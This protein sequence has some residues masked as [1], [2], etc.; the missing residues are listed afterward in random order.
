MGVCKVAEDSYQLYDRYGPYGVVWKQQLFP[1]SRNFSPWDSRDARNCQDTP[2]DLS[3]KIL[4]LLT[5]IVD[6]SKL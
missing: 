3:E 1:Q 5:P 6:Y 2:I 4:K